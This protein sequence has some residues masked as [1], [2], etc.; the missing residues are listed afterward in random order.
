MKLSVA[1]RGSCGY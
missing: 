1:A